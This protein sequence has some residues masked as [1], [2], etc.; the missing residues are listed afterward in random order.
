MNPFG[1]Y[2]ALRRFTRNLHQSLLM[3]LERSCASKPLPLQARV[4][5]KMVS[6]LEKK[7]ERPTRLIAGSEQ[8]FA[9]RSLLAF[10]A[11]R[12]SSATLGKLIVA[13][14]SPHTKRK[15]GGLE[16]ST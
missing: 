2:A 6:T 3:F 10:V 5:Q 12:S 15:A 16:I 7:L 13:I 1:E 11:M 14:V 4:G 9:L 8:C